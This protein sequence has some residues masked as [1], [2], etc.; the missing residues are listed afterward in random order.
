[1]SR[2]SAMRCRSGLLASNG[3]AQ[4]LFAAGGRSYGFL[5]AMLAASFLALPLPALAAEAQPVV[6]DPALEARVLKLSEDLRCLVC[7]N[8]S[9]AESN[10]E[11]ALDLRGQ[12]REQLAAGKSEGEVVDYMVARYGD[13]VLYRP[14]VKA[15]TLILWAG[16][17]LLR[18]GGLGWLAWRLASRRREAAP[19]LSAEEHA[20]ARAML[21]GG[22]S[23][24]QETER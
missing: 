10:A 5:R 4:D 19:D 11:L 6:A 23:E 12:V 9:I 1:M 15:S 22:D 20:R 16:P 2:I 7:Q 13:F 3:K 14:P 8:Q 24:K 18:A 21:D 17:G